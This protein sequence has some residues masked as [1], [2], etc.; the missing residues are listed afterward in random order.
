MIV[1]LR[2]KVFFWI[3]SWLKFQGLRTIFALYECV[4]VIMTHITQLSHTFSLIRINFC[5]QNCL[6]RLSKKCIEILRKKRKWIISLDMHFIFKDECKC[7][8]EQFVAFSILLWRVMNYQY[9]YY[10]YLVVSRNNNF[11]FSI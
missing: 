9:I 1:K 10:W 11:M 8:A 5:L 7:S 3:Y 2:R 6:L 4:V